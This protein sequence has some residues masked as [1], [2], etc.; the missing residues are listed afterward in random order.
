M[1]ITVGHDLDGPV[2]RGALAA[3]TAHL[4]ATAVGPVGLSRLLALHLG[5]PAP[6]SLTLRA[7]TLIPALAGTPGFWSASGAADP[8]GTAKAVLR[9]RDALVWAGWL[10]E[11]AGPRL[12]ALWT[13]TSA[14]PAGPADTV[15]LACEA[16]RGRQL[17]WR[18][19]SVDDSHDRL[20]QRVLDKLAA[21]PAGA[22]PSPGA[23][24][25]EI[26]AIEPASPLDAAEVAA[27]WLASPS[28]RLVIGQAPPL[29]DALSRIG[30]P[31]IGV[32]P[33]VT[34]DPALAVLPAV[35][36]LAFD[37]D[38][39]IL[40]QRLLRLPRSP[41]GARTRRR[42][43][44]A[45]SEWP[46][47]KSPAWSAALAAAEAEMEPDARALSRRAHDTIFRAEAAVP[48][49]VGLVEQWAAAQAAIS[50]HDAAAWAR[51][52]DQCRRTRGLLD[53][54]GSLR[55]LDVLR[56]VDSA[57]DEVGSQA[58]YPPQAGIAYTAHPGAVLAEADRVL[59]W[60][61]N[62]TLPSPPRLTA[63]ERSSL[64]ALGV[65]L[66]DATVLARRRASAWTRAL[67]AAKEG[68]LVIAPRVDG[69]GN[70]IP[71]P[72]IVDEVL[73]LA[74]VE[75]S[76]ALQLAAR[77]RRADARPTLESRV[78][79][80]APAGRLR[81]REAESP[82]STSTLL[83]CSL[84]WA[85]Q[86]STP[87]RATADGTLPTGPLL[88]GRLAHELLFAVLTED[89]D[90]GSAALATAME[91]R[92]DAQAP[93]I[94]ATLFLPGMDAE[95]AAVRSV[96]TDAARVVGRLMED[97]SLRVQKA[98]EPIGAPVEWLNGARF[99]GRPDLVLGPNP[100]LVL[101]F[102]WSLRRHKTALQ[103]G[104]AHQ[105]AAYQFPRWWPR[106][107][108]RIP[109]PPAPPNVL[110]N[111]D[112]RARHP[113]CRRP[114]AARYLGCFHAGGTAG[115]CESPRRH[116]RCAR[117]QRRRC[118]RQARRW[119]PHD[120][121]RL[122]VLP[123][124]RPLRS[125]RQR[126]AMTIEIVSASAGSGKTYRITEIVEGEVRAGRARPEAVVAVTF[127]N[128]A[129][130][131]L[132][133]RLRARFLDAGMRDEADRLASARIGTVHSVFGRLVDDF[134]IDLGLAPNQEVLD[135]NEAHTLFRACVS[136][137]VADDDAEQLDEL[138]QRMPAFDWTGSVARLVELAR[139]NGLRPV[140]LERSR[141]ASVEGLR[142]ALAREVTRPDYASLDRA[143]A[144]FELSAIDDTLATATCLEA[145]RTARATLRAGRPLPWAVWSRLASLEPGAKVRPLAEP[146]RATARRFPSF[147]DL[148]DDLRVAIERCFALAARAMERYRREK[149]RRGFVDFVDQEER[150]YEALAHPTVRDAL[151]GDVDLVVVDEFQD[152]SP[153]QVALFQRLAQVSPRSV[154]VGDV[155]QAIYGFRSTDPALMQA[156]IEQILAGKPPETLD[157]S[158]R[159]R[160]ELV[161]VTSAVF[162]PP[163]ESAGV[164]REQVVLSPA[165]AADDRSLGPIAERWRINANTNADAAH[166]L[167]LA[168]RR[169]LAD[170]SVRVRNRADG[171]SR[172][173]RPSDVAILCRTNRACRAVADALAAQDI[174]STTARPGLLRTP[175]ARLLV[176]GLKLSAAP[177]DVLAAAE[178]AR[179]VDADP[180]GAAFNEALFAAPP[181]A[182]PFETNDSVVAVREARK[183]AP[184]LGVVDTVDTMRR[185]LRLD[186][187]VAAWGAT[188][189]RR[190]NLEALRQ[191]AVHYVATE[192][193]TASLVGFIEY[194]RTLEADENDRIGRLDDANAVNVL[195]WHGS[196]GLE[197][198]IVVL[199]DLEVVDEGSPI[200]IHVE[201]RP[202]GF[203][204][205]DVLKDRWL[206]FWP[207]PLLEQQTTGPFFDALATTES[208]VASRA[209]ARAQ[210][211]RLLYVAWTRA[212]DRL[213]LAA[214][215]DKLGAGI[216]GLLSSN[217][218]PLVREPMLRASWGGRQFEIKVREA[219]PKPPVDR[220]PEPGLF[221]PSMGPS[222]APP[223]Y[224]SPSSV[225]GNGVELARHLLGD[226]LPA[227][228]SVEANVLGTAF[229]DI[230]AAD[231][232]S[233]PLE[234]RQH[235][236]ATLL[237]AAG[238]S[239]AIPPGSAVQAF[240]RLRNWA[241]QRWPSGRWRRECPVRMALAN[242][243]EL[244]GT[245][246][247]LI[248]TDNG[249][250]VV[251]HKVF[252][253]GE[254]RVAS[255]TVAAF[256]QLRAY[257]EIISTALNKP[258]LGH[259]V[260][261]PLAGVVVELGPE[262]HESEVAAEP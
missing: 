47:T 102:K 256:G 129:A 115:G 132:A 177:G 173:V 164:P 121:A 86:Y 107:S 5:L 160:P 185:V 225:H 131:E 221:I 152:S 91:R 176:A 26:L 122:R 36:A 134:A 98:E 165:S 236:A 219:G 79:W 128:R 137:V 110:H 32:S 250:A 62:D 41:L 148:H 252:L 35:V 169:T 255:Q 63:S 10:G 12:D 198:P 220:A 120:R 145:V 238:L 170:T 37:A 248:E 136:F 234:A 3:G 251:D 119:R 206:R 50:K 28:T 75:R 78:A 104:T 116:P 69:R 197:W 61:T 126:C 149:A 48:D 144:A 112:L 22:L 31:A 214:R 223:R 172:L 83:G 245:C 222:N 239:A 193:F 101:D 111:D 217:G 140:D 204:I 103:L 154:W 51:V 162:S 81:L 125:K 106:R 127:T 192:R 77:G 257:A 227:P 174:L 211:L 68:L 72:P 237:A 58:R 138:Q 66:P 56:L 232:T 179:L 65:T 114:A 40:A 9:W 187:L 42:L 89:R 4:G 146:I 147:V 118:R 156:A 203:D 90:A 186:E 6:A 213:V 67:S 209:R 163:F 200:G 196:K 243:S 85:L 16:M 175:E 210:E 260:H 64:A 14:A 184:L 59:W 218:L 180:T 247:L 161:R 188:P 94:A 244:R 82:N 95:R 27:E 88:Y 97:L 194:L 105:L 158:W 49:R 159:S 80:S 70:A 181:D 52:V 17:A 157:R 229:H 199:F 230:I 178:I 45:L 182:D 253:G 190:A 87:V 153:L 166:A 8:L 207:N 33:D 18:V 24:A 124:R 100:T 208:A 258:C 55:P 113:S 96:L 123:T 150:A 135:E 261:L 142:M 39:P 76:N 133:R 34:D 143:L 2:W 13:I 191:E 57:T 23:R 46:S 74:D 29:D 44:S 168:T 246:D 43:L 183:A 108:R 25:A 262:S 259:F 139:A 19:N 73:R 216:L 205:A 249:F 20:L 11:A 99:Q 92:F 84:N 54:A 151:S 231:D 15:R 228:G 235:R 109:R 141:D 21:T 167:A 38:H 224:V 130:D 212:R 117:C 254:D 189:Q 155:K 233:D 241:V 215:A 201:P 226:P 1:E 60:A 7:A 171:A 240:D 71:R 242:G 202:S 93:A 53:L 30:L 195:T